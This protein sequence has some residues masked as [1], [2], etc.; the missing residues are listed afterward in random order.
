MSN[1]DEKKQHFQVA[2]ALPTYHQ[3]VMNIDRKESPHLTLDEAFGYMFK[4]SVLPDIG[5]RVEWV[6]TRRDADRIVIDLVT[7]KN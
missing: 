3:M 5:D 1:E 6:C 2:M 4:G 7:V